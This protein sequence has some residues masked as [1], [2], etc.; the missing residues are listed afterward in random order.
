MA[1]T[2][3]LL[4]WSALPI[5]LHGPPD[6]ADSIATAQ[7]AALMLST[8]DAT[9]GLAPSAPILAVRVRELGGEPMGLPVYGGPR[10]G[11]LAI[12][13]TT[14]AYV[15]GQSGAALADVRWDAHTWLKRLHRGDAVG[16][17]H[18][19]YLSITAG[20]CLVFLLGTGGVMYVELL[21]R[22]RRA[23]RHALFWR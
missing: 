12:R 6:S 2:G 14:R 17:M 21:L 20:L 13:P 11:E 16:D 4:A 3:T 18:G 19:R 9:R 8:Y 1:V 22:R 15:I 10:P 7:M 23:G 5:E